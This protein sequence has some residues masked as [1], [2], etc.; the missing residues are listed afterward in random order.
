MQPDLTA[1]PEKNLNLFYAL[2]KHLKDEDHSTLHIRDA[3]TD[4]VAF[5]RKRADENLNP[6]LT[7]SLYDENRTAETITEL[8]T[9]FIDLKKNFF[10]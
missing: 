3:E 1:P 4:I 5:L 9:V 10:F 6:Q 8:D 2:D 7:V